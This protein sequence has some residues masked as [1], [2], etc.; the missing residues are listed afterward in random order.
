MALAYDAALDAWQPA[1]ATTIDGQVATGTQT[2]LR[3]LRRARVTLLGGARPRTSDTDA[4]GRFRFDNVPS[5][6]RLSISKPGYVTATVSS[7]ESGATYVLQRGGAIEGVV[8]DSEGDPFRAVTVQALQV[9]AGKTLPIKTTQTDDLGHYRLHSLPPGDYVVEANAAEAVQGQLLMPGEKRGAVPRMYYP[10]ADAIESAKPITVAAAQEVG[11]IELRLTRPVPTVDPAAP[12]P[13]ARPDAT[14]TARITGRVTDAVSGK[15]VRNARLLLVP[16][17]GVALTNWKRAD[18]Q[19]RF[20]YTQLQARR[21][22]LTASADGL[23]QMEY[24]QKRPGESG[25]AI[26]VG[27]GEAFKA[28]VALPRGGVIEGVLSDEF[29]DPAADVSVKVARKQFVAGR[30]RLVPQERREQ[31][32]VTD[33]R[34]RYRISSLDPGEYYV[35]ALSG[36]FVN[37]MAVGGFGPTFYPGTPDAGAASPIAVSTGADVTAAF[38]LS[39]ARTVSVSGRMVDADGRPLAGRGSLMLFTRDSLKRPEFHIARGG[40]EADGTFL[41][42]NVPEGNYTLQGYGSP[43]PDYKGPFNL[44]AMPFGAT[45]VVVADANVDDVVLKVTNGT[46]L[47]GTILLEDPA[48]APPSAQVLHVTAI[49]VEF[50]TAPIGGGPPPSEVRPDLTFEVRRLSGVR[51]ILVNVASPNWA[52]KKIAVNGI[53]VT[54]A[55]V[56]FRGA[57]VEAEILLTPKVTRISGAVADEKGPIPDYAVVI[58]PSDPAKW[59]DRSRFVAMARPTQQGRFEMRGLP[60]EEYLAIALPGITGQEFMDPEFLQQLRAQATAFTLS[61]GE[62]KTLDLRLKKKPI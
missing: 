22:R 48:A 36:V 47:R 20:E 23:I 4:K 43:P 16:L 25:I 60:P 31:Q 53:D 19:G 52:L 29:G 27:E 37:E 10:A 57:D 11:A 40:L 42:R 17:D 14:G 56:D 5:A 33:D 18:A 26:Q 28:D 58:F 1:A 54:D 44:G 12:P 15:P 41:L 59:T 38:A 8:L 62:N 9:Q 45:P 30:H 34:G 39:P 7:P 24:G 13:P 6:P 21:Y 51:R 61:E 2:D 35:T 49:P 46:T 50:D 32:A 55:P 3:P